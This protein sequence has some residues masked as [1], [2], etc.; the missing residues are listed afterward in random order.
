M[1]LLE[2]VPEFKEQLH[3]MISVSGQW[4]KLMLRW[5]E[6]CQEFQKECPEWRGLSWRAPKTYDLMKEILK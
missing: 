2:A 5:D 4:A 6:L 3:L 1:L